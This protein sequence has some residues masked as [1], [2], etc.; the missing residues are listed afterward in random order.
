MQTRLSALIR[1]FG[2]LS[3]VVAAAFA[4]RLATAHVSSSLFPVA[5]AHA[6][7]GKAL[8][9]RGLI[10]AE[11][12]AHMDRLAGAARVAEQLRDLRLRAGGRLSL[13]NLPPA[14]AQGV[15]AIVPISAEDNP[16]ARPFVFRGSAADKAAAVGC[17]A[18]AVYYEAG[19]EPTAGGEAVAQVVLNRMRHPIFPH[20][21]CGVVYQGA[22]LRTGCQ[23][24]F[25]C[26][27]ALARAPRPAAWARARRIAQRALTGYVM[28]GVGGATHYHTEWIVPWW[29]PTV[30][31]VGQVGAH[32]FYRWPGGL[33]LPAAFTARYAGHERLTTASTAPGRP[34]PSAATPVLVLAKAGDDATAAGLRHGPMTPIERLAAL[35]ATARREADPAAAAHPAATEQATR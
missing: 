19:F 3:V 29:R 13:A 9:L 31:K 16:P 7:G 11:Q 34:V 20:T 18:Q 24:S 14:L 4:A 21:V 26:D 15:N 17:L 6:A 23:F 25:T 27:G 22:D 8:V 35:A 30:T 28:A 2:V 10:D 1:V 33:G 5:P 12:T 32:I